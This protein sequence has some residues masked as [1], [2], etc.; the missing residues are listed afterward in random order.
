M[1]SFYEQ[2][3][4]HMRAILEIQGVK[5]PEVLQRTPERWVTALGAMLGEGEEDTINFTTFPSSARDM[6]VVQDI[7]FASL[8]VHHLLPFFGKAHVAY[9]PQG[10]VVGLSKIPRLVTTL[11]QG[12]WTQE[13]LTETIAISFNDRLKP[14]GVGVVM[15]A[16]HTCMSVRGVKAV[17][18]TTTT[19]CMMGCFADHAKLAR[20]EFLGFIK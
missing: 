9:V 19:S 11:A 17:G 12:L 4:D 6:V 14:I 10:K 3:V 20:A 7:Q 13:E 16:E 2:Q 5:D 15:R 18:T 8:C 1:T